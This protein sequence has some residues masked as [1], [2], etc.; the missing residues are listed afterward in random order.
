MVLQSEITPSELEIQME[1]E[2]LAVRKFALQQQMI[3]LGVSVS[4]TTSTLTVDQNSQRDANSSHLLP[5]PPPES[6]LDGDPN[7]QRIRRRKLK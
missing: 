3:H 1:M 4:S 5:V 7:L 2:R 6:A